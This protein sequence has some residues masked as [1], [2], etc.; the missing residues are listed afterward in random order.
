MK[1]DHPEAFAVSRLVDDRFLEKEKTRVMEDMARQ[2]MYKIYEQLTPGEYY[3]IRIRR[4]SRP[5]LSRVWAESGGFTYPYIDDRT[6]LIID[7]SLT[8]V[9]V[10]QMEMYAV[11][12]SSASWKSLSSSAAGE[13]KSRIKLKYLSVVNRTRKNIL[14]LFRKKPK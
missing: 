5:C 9:H 1:N 11:D 12:Y 2:L 3:T 7:A 14:S 4:F 13:I 8:K 10:R 6:E